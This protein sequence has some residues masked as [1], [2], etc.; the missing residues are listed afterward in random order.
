MN[1]NQIFEL[2]KVL[3][4]N[5]FQKIFKRACNKG[6][7]LLDEEDEY[8][9][10]SLA[11][12]GITVIYRD[13]QY[14][15]KVRLLIDTDLVIDDM[16]DTDKLLHKL[17]KRIGKY[18]GFKYQ[19]NDFTLSGMNLVTDIGVGNRANVS[20]YL[21]VLQRVGKIKGLSPVS[22]DCFDD[23]ASFCLSGNSN[24]IDFL[25]YDLEKATIDQLRSA[26]TG[27]KKLESVSER[28]KGVLRA[29]VRLTKPKAIRTYTEA[30]D[31][32]GQ[33]VELVKNR[34][35]VFMDT[36]TWVVPY[37]DFHKKDRA[38]EIIHQQVTDSTMRR[39]MIQ[40]VTLIPEKK[41]LYLA[42]KAMNCRNIE[43]VMK[44]FAK[45]N[46][47]PITISKRHNITHLDNLYSYLR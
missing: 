32:S 14:K 47:S 37:G 41:S 29:E 30:A 43:K 8:L 12:K 26:D 24:G 36:F 6:G 15:K 33:I 46:L 17:D 38:I 7:Y 13:S 28:T 4:T 27:R 45:I 20:N 44:V 22:F 34:T 1:I 16:T 39:R 5:H 19:M 31:V 42:H 21:K 2:S 40:L 23:N 9:N 35:D 11:G 10:T 3:D 18:F 25:L